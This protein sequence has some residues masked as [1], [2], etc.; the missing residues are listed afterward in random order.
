MIVVLYCPEL[1]FLV[2]NIRT[3]NIILFYNGL[4]QKKISILVYIQQNGIVYLRLENNKNY[5]HLLLKKTG[6]INLI[7]KYII[8]LF[9]KTYRT[10]SEYLSA[11]IVRHYTVVHR[12]VAY[13]LFSNTDYCCC[14]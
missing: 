2:Q 7:T 3:S 14:L 6:F 9:V 1:Y 4:L 8:F 11:Y 13:N 5:M 12:L 10:Y